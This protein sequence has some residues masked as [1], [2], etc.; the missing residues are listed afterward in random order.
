MTP[1][2]RRAGTLVQN[3]AALIILSNDQLHTIL[4]R[5]NLEI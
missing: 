2:F 3:L 5:S 4:K 1:F